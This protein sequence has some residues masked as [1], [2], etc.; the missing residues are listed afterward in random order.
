MLK[1]RVLIFCYLLIGCAGEYS[2]AITTYEDEIPIVYI[3]LNNELDY[4]S[5]EEYSKGTL[6]IESTNE[7]FQLGPKKVKLRGRGNTTWSFPKK[8]FQLKFEEPFEVLGM[9]SARKWLLMAHYSDKSLLRTELAFDLSRTSDLDW[10]SDS[11]FVELIINEEYLGLYQLVEKIEATPNRVNSGQGFVLEYNRPGR[12]G[13]DDVYFESN[14]H[15]YTIK[16][17]EVIVGD[18]QFELI[19]EYIISTENVLYG[20]DFKDSITGYRNYLDEDSFVDWYIVHEI[21]KN[22]ESAWGSS[23]YMNYVPG[24][25]LK[26]GPVWDFDPSLG[27]DYRSRSTEGFVIKN[28]GWYNRLFQDSNFVETIKDRF[29]HFYSQKDQF[30]ADMNQHA[31]DIEGAQQRNFVKWPILGVWV[32]PNAVS[33]TEY[34]HEVSYLSDWFSDRMDWL[35]IAIEDL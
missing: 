33:F 2:P 27:N 11:R 20:P 9:A 3:Q 4:L 23:C 7:N 13:T 29:D 15:F 18:N 19:R 14:F 35:A 12:L 6:Q 31:S 34:N 24:E 26:M 22:H 8:P 30:I 21:T 16:E 32:W 5:K 10:T 1:L 17:P 28:A 25:K